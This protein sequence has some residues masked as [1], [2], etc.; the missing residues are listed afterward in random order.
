M[1]ELVL[2]KKENHIAT[3]I[4]NQPKTGNAL[5]DK[6]YAAIIDA[7]DTCEA[8]DDVYVIVFTGAGKHFS[9]GGNI[10]WFK[11]M[12][13]TKTIL[14][15]D[16]IL[17]SEELSYKIRNSS[18][19]TI[20][21]VNH[22]AFGA[23][24]SIACACDF[25]IV[26]PQTQFCM[27]F[28]NVGLSGDTAGQFYLTKLVGIPLA[29]EMMLTGKIVGGEEAKAVGLATQLVDE[30]KLEEATYKFAKKLSFGPRQ[31]YKRQKE[32]FNTYLYDHASF[33]DRYDRTEA[34]F[35]AESMHS[36]DFAEAVDAFLE[37]RRPNFQ[38]K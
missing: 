35:M 10:A 4:F 29:T 33:I 20:A 5:D 2:V 36:A 1:E 11:E 32:L 26:T 14:N 13:E 25:R 24:C 21:M 31:A 34:E 17:T 6:C 15:A 9:S 18:K 7:V 19:P 12:I 3:I 22:A 30:D 8:D 23:G 27:A 38:G 16:Q 28:I 37:K